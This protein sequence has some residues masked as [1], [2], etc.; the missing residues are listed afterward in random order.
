[1]AVDHRKKPQNEGLSRRWLTRSPPRKLRDVFS[2]TKHQNQAV[3]WSRNSS[4]SFRGGKFR[5]IAEFSAQVEII[6][7][8]MYNPIEVI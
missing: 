5:V 7:R 1:M 2:Q 4:L 6:G 3:L 8:M